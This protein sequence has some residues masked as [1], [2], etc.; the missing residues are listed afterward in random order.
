MVLSAGQ[1]SSGGYKTVLNVGLI[2]YN[3]S[4]FANVM[5]QATGDDN[6][7]YRTQLAI[8]P[9]SHT[10]NFNVYTPAG[11]ANYTVSLNAVSDRRLKDDIT[12]ITADKSWRNLANL[13]F[14]SF[15]FKSDEQKRKRRG[16]IAQQAEE[17]E[18]LY[19]KTR[20]IQHEGCKPSTDQKE[21]DTTPM[22]L[23]TMHVVQ[24]LMRRVEKLESEIAEL[25]K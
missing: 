7:Q 14:V 11:D 6:A 24:E 23:D 1:R 18:P 5:L 13:E 21:L 2:H 4:S 3:S 17:V 15:V 8:A 19:V 12:P 25:K 22:L 10:I 16:V 20:V 9:N